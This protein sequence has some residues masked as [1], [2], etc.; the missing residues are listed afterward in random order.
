MIR[1]ADV[2]HGRNNNFHLLRL[3]A[4]SAV[5]F[6]HSYPLATGDTHD[7]PLRA[8]F[9]C[10]FGSIAVDLFFLISGMLVTMSLL[11]RNSAADFARARF[12][13]IWPALI[14][15]VFATLLIL[16]PAFTTAPLTTYFSSKETLRYL[17]LN[18]ILVKGIAYTL[19]GVFHVNPA[20]DAVN[21]SL[22]TLPSEV[23]CYIVLLAGWMLLRKIGALSRIRLVVSLAWLALL[24]WHLF[25]LSHGT[26]E[27][28]PARLWWMFCSGAM[29]Y[30]FR[31]FISLS[32]I[33][34]IAALT[35]I[36]LAAGH[37]L[38][39]GVVYSLA[40]PYVMLCLAYVPRGRILAFNRLGDYSYGTYIYAFP[41]QQS[42]MHLFPS[43]LPIPLFSASL[44]ATLVLAVAS[45]HFIEKPAADFAKPKKRHAAPPLV[46]ATENS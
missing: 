21:G 13:R 16:G 41:V 5:L 44:L 42:L 35:A 25:S 38:L 15:A 30:V 43:L 14:T 29:L 37:G 3:A 24:A 17:V 34:L 20:P 11:R 10:T 28:S 32:W 9:G 4:A 39:F 6:S 18:L 8:S 33:G 19:P 23:R 22:W 36:A 31:E 12:F 2:I 27:D 45:W 46:P 1:L 26:L 7:E 40:L